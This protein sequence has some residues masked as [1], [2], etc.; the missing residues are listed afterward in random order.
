MAVQVPWT[1]A[2]GESECWGAGAPGTGRRQYQARWSMSGKSDERENTGAAVP[3]HLSS[4][5]E[6]ANG[7]HQLY[8]QQTNKQQSN[9]KE[10]QPNDELDRK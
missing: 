9:H 6:R 5:G 4:A 8:K 1:V 3:T 2:D 10:Q 7:D